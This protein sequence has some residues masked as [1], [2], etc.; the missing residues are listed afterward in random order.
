M[1]SVRLFFPSC[2]I[3][4]MNLVTIRSWNFGSGRMS[5]RFTSPLRG[6]LLPYAGPVRR[7]RRTFARHDRPPPA[8]S[9]RFLGSVLRAALPTIL[10]SDRVERAADDVVAH[11]GEVLH[12]PAADEDH[13]VLLQIVADARDVG[14]D[15]DA[16]GQA[17]TR[18]FSECRIG[19]LRGRGVDARA[20]AALLRRALQGRRRL[21]GALLRASVLDELVDGR[22][23]KRSTSL[24]LS[25]RKGKRAIYAARSRVSNSRWRAPLA[26]TS[27]DHLRRRGRRG[28]LLGPLRLVGDRL[29][30]AVLR[31]P[32]ARR[33]QAAHDDVLLQ[34]DQAVDLAVDRGLGQD[35]GGLLEGGG[36]DEALG[37]EARLGDAEE[38][39]LGH[40]RLPALGEHA[41]VL[42]LEAPLLHLVA[43]QEVGVAHLLD[44]HAAE[45]LP[46]DHLDVLVV[47]T[48]ALQAVDLLHLVHQ[49]L[50]E[51]LLAEDGED[52]VRVRAAVHERLARLHVVALVY[53]DVLALG[54]Q[55]LARL[56]HLGRDH[57]LTLALGV[58]AEGHD[59]VDLADDREL[60]R[61]ARLEEL[62]DARQ[63]AGDVL[64]L[65]GLARHLGDD[66]ARRH[67]L[68]LE[69]VQVRP[70]RQQVAR[71]ARADP[72][73]LPP[74]VLDRHARPLVDVLGVD[75]HLG[76]E[77][78]ALVELLLHGD[79][80][81][82]GAELHHPRT[83]GEDR[84]GVRVPLRDHL[85]TL[86]LLAVA[87]LE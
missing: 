18:N 29:H 45:H 39:R 27:R 3:E 53:A 57:H 70:D 26:R 72:G 60:L 17:H 24:K 5:R 10:D 49:V 4:L 79:A 42:L 23:A 15:L 16:V 22:H 14:R 21:L 8:L 7:R 33:N 25:S 28:Q 46:H 37:R 43:D 58:L 68:P 56:A 2:V 74:L 55:V 67:A 76:R 12:A 50:G 73:R 86:H 82:D 34:A 47:D 6:M 9:L 51:R 78:R 84:D 85:A 32:G 11:P 87:L 65:G 30:S 54:D 61:L 81:E 38:E 77:P 44:A 31:H 75:D 19:L 20:H 83:L 36:R 69:H 40:R 35:L 62:G 71:L 13:G 41:L 59:P 52:V 66:V 64:G 1:R 48:H 63:A 80:F